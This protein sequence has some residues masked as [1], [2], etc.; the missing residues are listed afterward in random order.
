MAWPESVALMV[1]ALW[2]LAL[3]L[4]CVLLV[5]QVTLM[6][7]QLSRSQGPY[8]PAAD[9]PPADDFVDGLAPGTKL[10]ADTAALLP[11]L[12]TGTHMLLTLT[13][14]CRACHDLAPQLA[15]VR[16]TVP[17]TLVLPGRRGLIDRMLQALGPTEAGI[18]RDAK[19]D[20]LAGQLDINSTPSVTLVRSGT[21][22]YTRVVRHVE[23]LYGVQDD[24]R[25]LPLVESRG[26]KTERTS[27][28]EASW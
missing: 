28:H 5:R 11:G 4:V 17:L 10:P 23:D 18:V 26:R 6:G 8:A 3:T 20:Q 19:A 12:Q 15:K 22:V 27:S 2:L 7:I 13:G 1:A 9:G 25:S 21:V 24:A 14:T 16:L